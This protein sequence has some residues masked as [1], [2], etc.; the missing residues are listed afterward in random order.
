MA[1]K[2]DAV[3]EMSFVLVNQALMTAPGSRERF[4]KSCGSEVSQQPGF[5][6]QIGG[7]AAAPQES[8]NLVLARDRMAL[9]LL[10]DRFVA[11][12]EF[13]GEADLERMA[14]VLALAFT[15]SPHVVG[16]A[17]FGY[18]L[19]LTYFHGSDTTPGKYLAARLLRHGI[20]GSIFRQLSGDQDSLSVEGATI[21]FSYVYGDRKWNPKLEPRA[22]DHDPAGQRIHLALNCHCENRVLS[23]GSEG[24]HRDL[25]DIWNHAH[26]LIEAIDTHD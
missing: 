7:A 22:R 15:L 18:N 6:L 26:L 12:R 10:P 23:L 16:R 4:I 8:P 17:T 20:G 1:P 3:L 24:I 13:P 2:V 25:L 11:K 9:E 5:V 14:D 19:A 21:G